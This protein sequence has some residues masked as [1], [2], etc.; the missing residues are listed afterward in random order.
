[1]NRITGWVA[2]WGFGAGVVCAAMFWATPSNAGAP[3]ENGPSDLKELTAKVESLQKEIRV[4]RSNLDGLMQK[5][6]YTREEIGYLEEIVAAAEEAHKKALTLNRIATS[7]GETEKEA[8]AELRL[9]LAKARL[10]RARGALDEFDQASEA[11]I[12]A[13]EREVQAYQAAF[14]AQTV[15][16]DVLLGAKARRAEAKLQLVRLRR[17]LVRERDAKASPPPQDC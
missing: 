9:A 17:E 7:G 14:D 5:E 16:S 6:S 3:P 12:G 1:M 11:A 13:A 2:V 8:A 4:L 15:T 10:A